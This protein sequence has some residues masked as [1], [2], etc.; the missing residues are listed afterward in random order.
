MTGYAGVCNYCDFND[1]FYQ[2]SGRGAGDESKVIQRRIEEILKEY[3]PVAVEGR[4]NPILIFQNLKAEWE[5]D[6][7]YTSSISTIIEHP[8]Y[9]AIINMGT[10]AIPLILH[11][12]RIKPNH[13]FVALMKITGEDPVSP[14]HKGFIG[15]MAEDWLRWGA[16]HNY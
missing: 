4:T 15:K 6:I 8:A 16:R 1:F 7:A 13:W 14:E 11:E 2:K 12:L 5:I 9:Q 10:A 3:Y